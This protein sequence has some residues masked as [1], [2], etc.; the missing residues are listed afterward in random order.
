MWTPSDSAT[1]RPALGTVL[2]GVPSVI[3]AAL[4]A[5]ADYTHVLALLWRF[6]AVA[7]GTIIPGGYSIGTLT[8]N[9]GV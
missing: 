5:I 1:V 8:L 2:G 9:P 6:N 4:Q 3:I 7:P